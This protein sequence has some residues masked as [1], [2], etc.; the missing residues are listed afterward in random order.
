MTTPARDQVRLAR[1]FV[2]ATSGMG[3]T[4]ARASGH[5]AV[6]R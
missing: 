3:T 2:P 4:E 6:V 5:E 1:E